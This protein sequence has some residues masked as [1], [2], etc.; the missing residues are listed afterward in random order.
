MHWEDALIRLCSKVLGS[1]EL[2]DYQPIA[3]GQLDMKL[4]T[5]PLTQRITDVLTQHGLVSH[6][7]QRALPGSKT[8]PLLLMA[9]PLL[10][11]G[12]PNYVLSF[13]AR[14]AFDTARHGALHLI[15]CHLPVPQ[16]VID[17]LLFLHRFRLRIAIA[18]RLTQPVHML[19]G[20]LQGNPESPLLYAL[21]LKPLLRAQGQRLHPPGEANGGLIQAIYR[22]P[23][24]GGLHAAALPPGCWGGGRIP[25]DDGHGAQ[26]RQMRQGRARLL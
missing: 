24:G 8:G 17:L 19:H 10:K 13:D 1:A 6:W 15:L 9:Q 14:K 7:Q 4:L 18:H 22:R 5:V 23:A 26:L 3:L 16:E 12:K 21:L 2:D 25:R 20:F 11:R